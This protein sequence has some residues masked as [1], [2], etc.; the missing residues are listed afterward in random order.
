MEAAEDGSG[1]EGGV[2]ETVME[3]GSDRTKG[4]HSATA[5]LAWAG[6]GVGV[7]SGAS[8]AVALAWP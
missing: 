2:M 7:G 6:V 3:G 8:P 4:R 1:G 5:A